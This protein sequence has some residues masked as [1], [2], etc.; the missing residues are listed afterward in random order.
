MYLLLLLGLV[1]FI[2]IYIL[3]SSTG[4]ASKSKSTPKKTPSLKLLPAPPCG[5]SEAHDDGWILNPYSTFPLTL[6]N[7]S[8][9]QAT[10]VFATI[11][12]TNPS[13]SERSMGTALAKCGARCREVDEYIARFWPTYQSTLG[14]LI[15]KSKKLMGASIDDQDEILDKLREDATLKLDVQPYCDLVPLFEDDLLPETLDQFLNA[16]ISADLRVFYTDNLNSLGTARKTPPTDDD[17]SAYDG[18]VEAGLAKRGIDLAPMLILGQIPMTRLRKIANSTG[19]RIR[20]RSKQVIVDELCLVP[21]ILSFLKEEEGINDI[22]GLTIPGSVFT[23]MKEAES[24]YSSRLLKSL[25][26]LVS[27][28]LGMSEGISQLVES[29][30]DD[31]VEIVSGWELSPIM[32]GA[33]CPCC[34]RAGKRKYGRASPPRT[35]VHLGCRC[36][37]SPIIDI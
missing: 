26:F 34:K 27:H 12:P 6:Y 24:A 5:V 3:M 15:E 11:D 35:P 36:L 18:L 16:Q 28:T 1:A 8:R 23:K 2:I 14:T 9:E 19:Y 4:S 10:E 13:S 7:V 21:D 37:S 20:R 25:A 33:T 30:C 29:A 22:F 17:R 32:D 31:D